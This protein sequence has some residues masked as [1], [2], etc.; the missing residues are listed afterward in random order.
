[1]AEYIIDRITTPNGDIYK[2]QDKVSGRTRY[3]AG[4]G[5]DITGNIISLKDLVLDCGTS[6][7][8]LGDSNNG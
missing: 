2:L 7:T 5:I 3:I 4:N 8:V 1:M 6:T